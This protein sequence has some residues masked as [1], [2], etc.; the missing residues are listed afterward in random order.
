MSLQSVPRSKVFWGEKVCVSPRAGAHK[1][2]FLNSGIHT[3][4]S[5][6]DQGSSATALHP[7]CQ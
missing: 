3:L 2:E 5:Y 6:G 4:A 1:F 7:Q